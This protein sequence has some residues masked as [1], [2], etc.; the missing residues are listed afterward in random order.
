MG[1]SELLIEFSLRQERLLAV[2]DHLRHTIASLS[3][4]RK[5]TETV[6]Q[7]KNKR[8]LEKIHQRLSHEI[9][10][11]HRAVMESPL[12]HLEIRSHLESWNQ[13]ARQLAH[14]LAQYVEGQWE[15]SAPTM[16]HFSERV[17]ELK[18]EL[19]NL[20]LK[21][22]VERLADAVLVD[23]Y[24]SLGEKQVLQWP[25]K[26]WHM[27]GAMLVVSIYL[28]VPA[29]FAAKITVFGFFSLTLIIG[30]ITRLSWPGFNAR[31]MRDLKPYMRKREVKGFSSMTFFALAAFLVCLLFPKGIAILSVLYLGFGDSLAS[32]VGVQWGKHRL[33]RRFTWEGSL[34]FFAVCFVLTWL[35]PL[36]TPTFS[37]SLLTL[38]FAGGL[39]G[40]VSEWLSFRLDDNLVIPLSSALML[41]GVLFFL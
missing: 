15:E 24:A 37:G 12:A 22:A 4:Q 9:E 23:H 31:V 17:Q 30:E 8:R 2:L 14:H 29:S 11:F 18:K 7:G 32:I 3:G 33:G 20:D 26:I 39:I 27:C 41:Q 1:H 10:R 40:M 25:R 6:P 19:L 35:Y 34:T 13:Q 38:A 21:E 5:V 28:F 36:L 16:A